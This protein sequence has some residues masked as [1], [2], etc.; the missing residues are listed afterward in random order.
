MNF[1]LTNQIIVRWGVLLLIIAS[2]SFYFQVLRMP[3]TFA[4]MLGT[5]ALLVATNKYIIKQNMQICMGFLVLLGC[6]TVFNLSNGFNMNDFVIMVGKLLFIIV[7]LSNLTLQEFKGLYIK[8]MTVIAA[9]SI[10]CFL[11]VDVF[12][13]SSLPLQT[14]NYSDAG[15]V[16]LTPYYTVGWSNGPFGRNA[17]PFGEPGSYQIFLNIALMYLLVDSS[18]SNL[19]EVEK[20]VS[21]II[22][23]VAM[24]TTMSA[25]GYIC[26]ALIIAASIFQSNNSTSGGKNVKILALIALI[27]LY[28]IELNNGFI[29]EK[30]SG[31]GSYAVRSND[32]FGGLKIVLT[33][34]LVGYGLLQTNRSE[35]LSTV[36]IGMISN[37]LVS[38]MIS[39]GVPLTLLY[40]C[41]I[42]NGIKRTIY[43]NW[44]TKILLFIFYF[45]CLN[46]EG[47]ALNIIYL[48]NL[49][50]WKTEDDEIY[51]NEGD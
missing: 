26:L 19:S 14:I 41:C 43:S 38:L 49:F 9:I 42:Y 47:G 11:W 28:I 18:K 44:S 35:L 8:I 7:L 2:G 51:E 46:A 16:H 20:K 15:L 13:I 40:L 32:T 30:L 27:V 23:V 24:L 12:A 39:L 33:R 31:G 50:V 48:I 17:G 6:N 1:R 34:P 22:L 25:T 21:I 10:V 36:N 29:S 5:V 37:G 3:L 45:L 4:M